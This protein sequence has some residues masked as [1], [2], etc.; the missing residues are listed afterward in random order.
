MGATGT[1]LMF[2][3]G[4]HTPFPFQMMVRTP[5]NFMPKP[6][7]HDHFQICYVRKGSC[8]NRIGAREAALVEGDLFSIPPFLEHQITLIPNTAVE[9]VQIDFMPQFINE[10]MSD[11]SNMEGFVDFAY[12]QPLMEG[13]SKAIPKLNLSMFNQ[14]M[15]EQII[16][17]IEKELQTRDEGFML[18]IRAQLLMLLIISGR[19]YRSFLQGKTE[20]SA[21]MTH[22][23]SF[24]DTV[25][26]IRQ[27]YADELTLEDMAVRALMAPTYFSS[28]FKL[29]VGRTFKEY[30]IELRIRKAMELLAV[31]DRNITEIHLQVGFNNL[32]YFIRVFK[33]H[34][35]LTPSQ[36]RK[37]RGTGASG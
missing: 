34:T 7:M 32:S 36:Y 2:K 35:G 12:L 5:D 19:E 30:I 22:R 17:V 37:R 6:H 27:H 13:G 16:A 18:S 33:Q 9:L 11:L 3:L 1:P 25:E 10:S 15:L 21:L 23:K 8:K 4:E 24:H 14:L 29:M 26:Y 28:M 31:S 20:Q